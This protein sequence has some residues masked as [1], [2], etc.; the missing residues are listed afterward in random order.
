MRWLILFIM[1]SILL[2]GCRPLQGVEPPA[3]NLGWVRQFGT[4]ERDEASAVAVDGE[5]NVYVTGQTEGSLPGQ[6]ALGQWDAF[7]RKYGPDGKELWTRQFGS[8]QDDGASGVAVDGKGNVYV[9]GS[10][11]GPLPGQTYVG[12]YVDAFIRKYG[13]DGQ[14]LWTRQFGSATWDEAAGVAADR[15]GNAY[16]VG[17]VAGPL[18]GQTSLGGDDAFLRKYD[19][20][21]Q[22]VWTR[23]FGSAGDDEALGVAVD[24]VANVYVVGGF[25]HGSRLQHTIGTYD[26]FLRKFDPVGQELWSRQIGQV[27]Y[28][29]PQAVDVDG[30]G[31]AYVTGG[32]LYQRDEVYLGKYDPEGQELWTGQA[33]SAGLH[34]ASD[35]TI[36]ATGDV[37]VVGTLDTPWILPDSAY[38]PFLRKYNAAGQELWTWVFAAAPLGGARGVALDWAANVY[39]VGRAGRSLLVQTHLGASDAFIIQVIGARVAL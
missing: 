11:G 9:V 35:V 6:T 20:E 36:D 30:A 32:T 21:G 28:T 2:S 1:T 37:Y 29:M 10:V 14:E 15:A 33:R 19:P 31:N 17:W 34:W 16:V 22:E 3:G 26:G 24:A 13:P 25:M 12:R 4:A 8:N 23:Q 7:L 27:G 5:G 38:D 39:I 18:P